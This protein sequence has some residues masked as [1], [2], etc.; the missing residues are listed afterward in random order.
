MAYHIGWIELESQP[1]WPTHLC[2]RYSWIIVFIQLFFS[3]SKASTVLFLERMESLRYLSE[4]LDT[5]LPKKIPIWHHYNDNNNNKS[6]LFPNED[7]KFMKIIECMKSID[8]LIDCHYYWLFCITFYIY[9]SL[10]LN[11]SWYTVFSPFFVYSYL[12]GSKH[13]DNA[14]LY[15]VEVPICT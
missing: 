11:S 1:V 15:L 10:I 3:W 2:T 6:H 8:W 13:A 9:V 7:A 12:H 14:I 4:Y 5:G